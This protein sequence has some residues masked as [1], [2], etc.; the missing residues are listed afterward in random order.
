M[1][2]YIVVDFGCLAS[3]DSSSVN[4][5][6]EIL[7]IPLMSETCFPENSCTLSLVSCTVDCRAS[8]DSYS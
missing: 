1:L 3:P 8:S 6:V 4:F 7:K 5:S 2:P